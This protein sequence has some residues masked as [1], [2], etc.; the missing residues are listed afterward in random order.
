M[1]ICDSEIYERTVRGS[2]PKYAGSGVAVLGRRSRFA[3]SG[4]GAGAHIGRS[5]DDAV[6]HVVEAATQWSGISPAK[7]VA[8]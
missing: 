7:E 6:P 2:H 5:T 8:P 3:K 1:D 4:P